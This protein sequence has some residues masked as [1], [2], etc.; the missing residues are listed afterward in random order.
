MKHS[1]T[2]IFAHLT[3][4][5][6]PIIQWTNDVSEV[7]YDPSN[8]TIVLPSLSGKVQDIV[9]RG[10]ILSNVC[11]VLSGSKGLYARFRKEEI[12][13]FIYS[14]LNQIR[15]ERLFKAHFG[16]TGTDL[17]AFY[18]HLA[19]EG[20]MKVDRGT[21][22]FE[23]LFFYDKH[24]ILEVSALFNGTEKALAEDLVHMK[25]DDDVI[26]LARKLMHHYSPPQNRNKANGSDSA[27]AKDMAGMQGFAARVNNAFAAPRPQTTK[28][29]NLEMYHDAVMTNNFFNVSE[30]LVLNRTPFV[31]Q[32]IKDAR[33]ADFLQGINRK[34]EELAAEFGVRK[35]AKS[36]RDENDQDNSEL[37]MNNLHAYRTSKDIFRAEFTEYHGQSHSVFLLL[38]FS[39]SMIG[40]K[41]K[42]CLEQTLLLVKFCRLAGIPFE[43]L[44][45]AVGET[46]AEPYPMP[47][48]YIAPHSNLKV[49]QLFHD[50]MSD[51]QMHEM[52]VNLSV[53]YMSARD[54]GDLVTEFAFSK[55]PLLNTLAFLP[56]YL[57]GRYHE[58]PVEKPTVLVISDGHT[59]PLTYM[60][61]GEVIERDF[62][63]MNDIAIYDE[64]SMTMYPENEESMLKILRDYLDGY[65][66]TMISVVP[67]AKSVEIGVKG[68][69]TGIENAY[70]QDKFKEVGFVELTDKNGYDVLVFMKDHANAEV[71]STS[72]SQATRMFVNRAY[73]STMS[74]AFAQ[75]FI[76]SI[77]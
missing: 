10:Y 72:D 76:N 22:L 43:V 34:A 31:M 53:M 16:G 51:N 4:V 68:N 47:E 56:V 77:V 74:K 26:V 33:I 65:G 44:A 58:Q 62:R 13:D 63:D 41:L 12:P 14:F 27:M 24:T 64:T 40:K 61:K 45:F 15:G 23:K 38:D 29:L 42:L 60:Q 48:K 11:T 9:Q 36:Y 57:E 67:G 69:T 66:F 59:H 52:S 21:G 35:A 71:F 8:N 19:E 3:A 37:D 30:C 6:N 55:T 5:G 46:S 73:V 18:R 7:G 50:T 39:T 1:Q 28:I 2:D 70:V 49:Y 75:I 32:S 25:S 54:R 20:I 17:S